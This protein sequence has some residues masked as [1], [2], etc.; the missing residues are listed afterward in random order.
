M[1]RGASLTVDDVSKHYGASVA[2]DSVSLSI[3]PGSY[4]VILGPSGSGKT[5]LLSLLGGFTQPT[6]GRILVDEGDVTHLPPARRP[7]TT[8]FQDYALFPHMTVG[9]NIGFGLTMHKIRGDERS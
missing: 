1:I 5:T 6:S 3:A 7:T 4:V 8:V 2:L 9:Q